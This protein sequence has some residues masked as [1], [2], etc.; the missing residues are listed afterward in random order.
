MLI[1]NENRTI[2]KRLFKFLKPYFRK[3]SV[4][5]VCI[6]AS[7]G[8]NLLLPLLSKQIM[9]NGLLVKNFDI[10]VRFSLL[11]LTI[12]LIEQAIGLLETK[13]FS[14]VNAVF[15]YSLQKMAFKHL[16]RL[17]LQYFNNTNF[18]EIMSNVGIDVG[19]I[20]RIC[21]KGTFIVISQIFRIIGGLFGLLIID[22][23]LTLV[24]LFV[25]PIR[26]FTVKIMAKK[27]KAMINK[28]IEYNSD[29]AS[30]YGDAISGIKE[31]KLWGIDRIKTGEF[32]K[33]QR[34]IVKMNIKMSFLDK[35]NECTETLLFQ[36]INCAL[37]VLGAYIAFRNGLTIGGVF[38]FLTY[39]TYVLGPISAILNIGYN[40]TNIIPSAKR[41][42]EFLDMETE[43]QADNKNLIRL[44]G[45]EVCGNIKFQEVSFS[46][47]NGEKILNKIN[48]NINSGEK[49][50]IIGANGSG[51]STLINLVLRFYKP[52]EGKI[53]IDGI[54]IDNIKLRDY[55]S[56][57]S[58]VS[59]DLY[60]FNTTIEDNISAGLKL[61]DSAINKA[62]IKSGAY[63]F[64]KD[65]PLK[66]KS[67]VGRNG[68]KL[69]GG[70]R[71]KVAMARAF[72][73]KSKILI[74][75][76]ATSN[77]DIESEAYVNQMLTT[78]FKDSTVLVISHKPDI[79][80][81]VNKIWV[82]D[83]G[84]INEF[85]NYNDFES[86]YVQ[87]KDFLYKEKSVI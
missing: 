67:K 32:I 47:K 34:S 51:K 72:A 62:A 78:D 26:C 83:S 9:D 68:S 73:R 48:L 5:F 43:L 76:E 66:Y 19:N 15:Q 81:M 84:K 60:L 77:Y 40:F 27:R 10:V 45:K 56:M 12:V 29:F 65:M 49:I 6:I 70:Q 41:F 21:D 82:M 71:Q 80:K 74:L 46:Y 69:S 57:I 55:R 3:I 86:N 31:I 20:S 33:K 39:S 63:D 22:W 37:Y 61:D 44:D 30:W 1:N 85:E 35:F 2:M 25:I 28:F 64:I 53:L 16:Q 87:Y 58:V 38:A 59:Q 75:D 23:K 50:A 18:S 24:V 14:Y 11:T 13:Y 4:V 79:L 17:K 8:I 36:G 42:I 52:Q 54:N 7:A